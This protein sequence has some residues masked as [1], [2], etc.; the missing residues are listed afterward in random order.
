M[1][2][3]RIKF[4]LRAQHI[5]G[6]IKHRT[7]LG[8]NVIARYGF[9][10]SLKDFSIPNPEE[11]DERGMEILP[12][13]LFGEH[14]NIYNAL[15]IDRLKKDGLDP[16]KYFHIMARAHIC[17]GANALSPRVRDLSDFSDL[18]QMELA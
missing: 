3:N 7:D 10:L 13:V 12:G 11:Y 1:Q 17:R 18:I 6:Q 2:F 5:Y 14:E 4:S 15:M 8:I 9:C 16:E